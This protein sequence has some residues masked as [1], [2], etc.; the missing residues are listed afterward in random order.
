MK[1][2]L[3]VL[4]G[5]MVSVCVAFGG[6]YDIEKN[7]VY[8]NFIIKYPQAVKEIYNMKFLECVKTEAMPSAYTLLGL[9]MKEVNDD[10]FVNEEDTKKI[11]KMLY[12]MHRYYM[13]KDGAMDE[14]LVLENQVQFINEGFKMVREVNFEELER[15]MIRYR[16]KYETDEAV[17]AAEHGVFKD[18]KN[19]FEY[20]GKWGKTFKQFEKEWK[21][22]Q[23][24]KLGD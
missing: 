1:K 23:L 2:L 15:L 5:L 7:N 14:Y 20:E 22:E 10:P 21:K 11:M 12:D 19:P 3:G 16:L 13:E 4:L 8:I 18:G 9:Q 24:K 17:C 6:K